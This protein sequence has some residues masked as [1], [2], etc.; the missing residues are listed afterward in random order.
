MKMTSCID[1][2]TTFQT[3][4]GWC[5]MLGHGPVLRALTFGHRSADLAESYLID[6]FAAEARRRRWNPKLVERV[7]AALE[8][9]PDEFRDVEIE[10]DHL[11]S[12][13]RRVIIACRRISWGQTR[14]YAQLAA[15]A[16]SAS[17]ARAVGHAMATNRTPLV[18]PCHRVIAS[19]GLLG[20]YSAPQGLAAKR[21]LLALESSSFVLS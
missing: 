19:G 13:S 21:R 8:G 6:R 20:G 3:T 17:A 11:T 5:A 16:G 10:L 4:F 18:V 9:D 12:F 15:A 7:V 14:S 1:E 2:L